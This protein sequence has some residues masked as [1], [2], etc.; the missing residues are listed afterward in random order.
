M[1]RGVGFSQMGRRVENDVP[2]THNHSKNPQST[3]KT[4]RHLM[5]D[6]GP[7]D[8]LGVPRGFT[9]VEL[10][11]V[12]AI[13]GLLIALLLPAVQSARESGRR[14][15]CGNNLKQLGLALHGF[16]AA[17]RMLPVSAI[18]AVMDPSIK[19]P[20]SDQKWKDGLATVPQYTALSAAMKLNTVADVSAN[21]PYTWASA[22]LPYL[23]AQAHYDSFVFGQKYWDPLNLP[24]T[25]TRQP[26]L[27][28]PSDPKSVD[29]LMPSRC[30][31]GSSSDTAP[32]HGLW[33]GGSMGPV[34]VDG[35]PAACPTTGTGVWCNLTQWNWRMDIGMF[36]R[37][38]IPSSFAKVRDGV[39]NTI[40][41]AETT[42]YPC[43]HNMAFGSNT[44]LVTLSIPINA[45]IPAAQLKQIMF[46]VAADGCQDGSHLT[47]GPRSEHV[48]GASMLMCD[49]SVSFFPVDTAYDIV[50]KLGTRQGSDVAQVP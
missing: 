21:S 26:S 13:I 36:G 37:T 24:A 31:M 19:T 16:E 5:N 27:I 43:A 20:T 6:N 17:R 49:G 1:L 25:T 11:A 15:T 33:Y 3:V 4:T 40:L 41:L 28:C 35:S 44:P 7:R 32:R 22:I 48:G 9:L 46:P 30:Y 50:C 10:L 39:S 14:L 42:P 45:L 12:I 18:Y 29:A 2:A 8:D 47:M 34:T 38:Q 23:E